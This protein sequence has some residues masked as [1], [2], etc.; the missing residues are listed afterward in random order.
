M[1]QSPNGDDVAPS[2]AGAPKV[3][4][5]RWSGYYIAEDSG[6]YEIAV[7]G[8]GEHNG[9]RVYI[10]DKLFDAADFDVISQASPS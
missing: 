6:P 3:T 7:L 2:S 1:G 10:D 5:R 8:P 9:Y 4:S